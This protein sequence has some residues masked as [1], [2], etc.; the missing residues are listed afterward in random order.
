[1]SYSSQRYDLDTAAAKKRYQSSP[2]RDY[3]NLDSRYRKQPY[4]SR[5]HDHYYR[6]PS[7][8]CSSSYPRRAEYPYTRDEERS[9]PKREDRPRKEERS[10]VERQRPRGNR[11]E[12]NTFLNSGRASQAASWGSTYGTYILPLKSRGEY[13]TMDPTKCNCNCCPHP[14]SIAHN[15]KNH[16]RTP[17][18]HHD[19]S[20]HMRNKCTSK[21]RYLIQ[22]KDRSKGSLNR[23]NGP[24]YPISLNPR[25]SC[26]RV[27]SFLAPDK[28]HA[29]VMV[30]WDDGRIENLGK[31]IPMDE[32]IRHGEYLE[33]KEVKQV[34][35]A[36]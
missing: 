28:R 15:H 20:K 13:R 18:L 36:A 8:P 1:M 32:L 4:S 31:Q 19:D 29:K 26:D 6:A 2:Q 27:A 16:R 30:H 17:G 22:V 14:S 35:W 5:D 34:H 33:V 9:R 7:V 3:R 21:G 11:E 23:E 10:R 24:S 12:V 25:T